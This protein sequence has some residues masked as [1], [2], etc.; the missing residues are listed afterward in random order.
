MYALIK[1]STIVPRPTA[2]YIDTDLLYNSNPNDFR[3][4]STLDQLVFYRTR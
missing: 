2:K 3:P 4:R 1:R